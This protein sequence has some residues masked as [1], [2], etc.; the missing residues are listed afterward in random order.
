M[1]EQDLLSPESVSSTSP[2]IYPEFI[3][4]PTPFDI[5]KYASEWATTQ[6][7]MN[8]A[9]IKEAFANVLHGHA[10]AFLATGYNTAAAV[11]RG[12]ASF[13]AHADAVAKYIEHST[14]ME[15]GGLFEEAAKIYEQNADYWKKKV[16]DV[17]GISFLDEILSEAV[18]GAV[19]GIS[20]FAMDVASGLT[21]PYMDGAATAYE[22]GESPF[23]G[24]IEQAA[25][26][27]ILAGLFRMI[28]PLK[29]YLQAPT[30]GTIFGLQEMEG[31]PEDQ[32]G[33][34]FAKGFGIGA[35]YSMTSPGGR[36]GLNEV[37]KNVESAIKDLGERGS[38]GFRKK[39]EWDETLSKIKQTDRYRE[40]GLVLIDDLRKQYP[41]MSKGDFDK[42]VIGLAQEG[43]IALHQ[44][45]LPSA[46]KKEMI[47]IMGKDRGPG[48]TIIDRP[49]FYHAFAVKPEWRQGEKKSFLLGEQGG[50]DFQKK[51]RKF[52]QTVEDAVETAPE[53]A[54]KVK[55][56]NPQDYIV[57]PNAESVATARTRI[58]T[59]GI[60][61]T[62]EY[63]KSKTPPDAEK[64]A[65]FVELSKHFERQGDYDR[66]SEM[67]ELYDQQ[68]REA[69]RFTQAASLW[70]QGSPQSFIR[71]ANKQ[72]EA[73][74]KKYGFSDRAL[75]NMPEAFTLTKNEQKEIFRRFK[76]I[77]NMPEGID[78]AD[79]TLQLI[80]IVA[81]K[82]P[83]SV[84]E[85]FDAYRYQNMLS[86]PRTQMRN[87]YQNMLSTFTQ[88]PAD[89]AMMSG[90][91]WIK[92]ATFGAE[93]E[94][95]V[96]DVPQYLKVAL[97]SVPNAVQAFKESLKMARGT[98][99]TKPEL[100]IEAKN[101][102]ERARAAQL[103][104]YLTVVQR[105]MEASDKFNMAIISPAEY[106]VNKKKGMSDAEAYQKG[107]ETAE[108]YLLRSK[109]DPSDPR[110]SY[111]S[112]ALSELGKI[113]TDTRKL[114]M[115]GPL[116]KLYIPFIKTPVNFGIQMIEHSPAGLARKGFDTEQLA[117]PM[118]GSI[119]SLVGL[120]MAAS[121][122]T[123]WA[124]P[125]DEKEKS[126]FYAS[127]KKPYSIKMGDTYIPVWYTGMYAFALGIPMALKHYT[128]D[129]RK[130]MTKEG[131][132]QVAD[133]LMSLAKFMGQQTSTQ[134]IGALFSV[135][136]GDLDH[137][138]LSQTG[139]TV[140]Q[141]IPGN[142]LVRYINTW[143]DPV[144]RKPDG[145]IENI[146]KD[147]P[148]LSMNLDARMTPL[149]E[150]SR[151]QWFNQFLPYDVGVTD[152]K[153]E[154]LYDMQRLNAREEYLIKRLQGVKGKKDSTPAERID[155][156]LDLL[157][158]MPGAFK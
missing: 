33:R 90:I 42:M 103:P 109:L 74:R 148:V 16:E 22:K 157:K 88:R 112:K 21:L 38:I 40:G 91:D 28:G 98:T 24:G 102:F 150:E 73:S 75:G 80:D 140:Q 36:M 59:E 41:D 116:A 142:A 100:G 105:F 111:P 152:Q 10:K 79:A 66:A 78:R 95:Y 94:H 54:D 51:P 131:Y 31:A 130:S 117:K 23:I 133:G 62:I 143:I 134:S 6:P 153:Y 145:F 139:F 17:G 132:E 125:T 156:T 89:L 70:G 1:M 115:L 7:A 55:A 37:A 29:K 108:T 147:L 68:L 71:W 107:Q 63:L 34:A 101:E 3:G 151:R 149:M 154:A 106:A 30:M 61:K 92:S 118:V 53:L 124:P 69:G 138:F 141:M 81:Q 25:K 146:E 85:I 93:R 135:L 155:E 122:N 32:K 11:N 136:D 158:A 44:H 60:D 9:G 8:A 121:G 77:S 137:S 97:N 43:K 20:Q 144:Y 87:I 123:T 46:Y 13:S 15:R 99:M 18:G 27:G 120:M 84:S 26:T 49:Y 104:K 64:G 58:S 48:N 12:M 39:G 2:Q 96:S 19:P 113:M 52:L 83:P 5:D 47:E 57:Q 82:V 119:V 56:I 76:E 126:L 86:S 35:G 67:I 4:D 45:D 14:G 127:G 114:K 110:L 65:T 50:A 72:L 129:E 128:A